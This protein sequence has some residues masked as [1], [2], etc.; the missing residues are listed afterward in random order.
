MKQIFFLLLLT[1][2][3]A[4][5]MYA[6]EILWQSDFSRQETVD[7]IQ[8]GP[9]LSGA[10]IKG[11]QHNRLFGAAN[12]ISLIFKGL[13]R[14]NLFLAEQNFRIMLAGQKKGGFC[15][16]YEYLK[17]PVPVTP[18]LFF[19]AYL[20]DN[21]AA[22]TCVKLCPVIESVSLK[23][24]RKIRMEIRPGGYSPRTGLI[25]QHKK[26]WF[27]CNLNLYPETLRLCR[28]NHA[29][30]AKA[31][32]IGWSLRVNNPP[33]GETIT[34]DV[35]KVRLRH[36]NGMGKKLEAKGKNLAL[37]RPYTWNKAPDAFVNGYNG[38]SMCHDPE[39]RTQLTNGISATRCWFD[40]ETVGW[41]GSSE[42]IQI[43]IDLGKE[44]PIGTAAIHLSS[45]ISGYFVPVMLRVFSSNDLKQY[46]LLGE[47]GPSETQKQWR[48][49]KD[50]GIM[51]GNPH[52]WLLLE[53]LNGKGRYVT[54]AMESASLYLDEIAIFPDVSSSDRKTAATYHT[55]DIT[56]FYKSTRGYVA[57]E[58]LTPLVL[59]RPTW[60][61]RYTLDV[62]LPS[63]VE[64]ASP[65]VKHALIHRNG[66][67]YKR[68]R[69]NAAEELYLVTTLP[70]GSVPL[71][72][73]QGVTDN[74]GRNISHLSQILPVE[75][76]SIPRTQGFRRL[77]CNA[78]FT[79]FKFWNQWPNAIKSY[80]HLGLN[81]FS[82]F[83]HGDYG[84]LFT[85][86]PAA[87]KLI[88]DSKA[89]GL[90]IGGNLSPF[91]NGQLNSAW[92]PVQRKAVYM[93]SG[94]QAKV[95]CPRLYLTDY[96]SDSRNYDLRAAEA[97][98][99]AGLEFMLFDSEPE[100]LGT[101]CR[102]DACE[103]AWQDFQKKRLIPFQTLTD[104]WKK[105]DP[106]SLKLLQQFWDEF[107][108]T[109]WSVFRKKMDSAA[110]GKKI[111]LGLYGLPAHYREKLEGNRGHFVPLRKAGIV[112]FANPTLYKIPL[113]KYGSMLRKTLRKV[114]SGVPA[115]VW[116]TC[117][118]TSL[119]Y[120]QS[121]E[122][123]LCQLFMLYLNGGKGAVFYSA[124]GID[125]REYQVIAEVIRTLHPYEDLIA[126]GQ[127]ISASEFTAPSGYEISGIG[128]GKQQ[129]IY[130][131]NF[132]EKPGTANIHTASPPK[133]VRAVFGNEKEIS[134]KGTA[135]S[136]RFEPGQ[137][138]IKVL[139]LEK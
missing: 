83:G 101:V 92:L 103:R 69:I 102:C 104:V 109:L 28:L 4:G 95:N 87:L 2:S 64:L 134:C 1:I 76:I 73:F 74:E 72:H 100:W 106:Q 86:N 17:K 115:Y 81:H 42:E 31:E 80:R 139:L 22:Q 47:L 90:S 79:N 45:Q 8:T 48:K 96:L 135:I 131:I 59:K 51:D 105:K 88:A 63:G 113:E 130:L 54:L 89:A 67:T 85:G 44:Q 25:P 114:P 120:E 21:G 32:F 122:D 11:E 94:L 133:N 5:T 127:V 43:T 124:Y 55:V 13:S 91:C 111:Q 19:T 78:G 108:V 53:N 50:S 24:G 121:P 68:Y 112:D 65:S 20:S 117:G 46:T 70:E 14:K 23:D 40:R 3:S 49:N 93:D 27:L 10:R 126:D 39:D 15:Y 138:K 26:D 136:V 57:R 75:V 56:P 60:R 119:S 123:L 82:P 6:E 33:Q 41:N 37:N 97:A 61:G 7:F 71:L 58:V 132:D 18:D 30:P 110:P 16:F 118:D 107:H 36:Q 38:Q 84:L 125:A 12:H 29:D 129:L 116:T 34:V 77:I 35:E 62:D 52:A 128:K 66:E 137:S 98:A 99:S 9:P